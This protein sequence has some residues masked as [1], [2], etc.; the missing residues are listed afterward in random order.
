MLFLC[1]TSKTL[2]RKMFNLHGSPENE[3]LH[4][5]P[6]EHSVGSPHQGKPNKKALSFQAVSMWTSG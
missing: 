6:W 3:G 1:D 5:V 4:C 2:F